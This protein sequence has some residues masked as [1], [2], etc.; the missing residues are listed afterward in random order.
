MCINSLC[1]RKKLPIFVKQS[2]VPAVL[3]I[4]CN[5]LTQMHLSVGPLCFK[6]INYMLQC[7]IAQ[8]L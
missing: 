2:T 5:C 3:L 8:V 7:Y 6:A 4:A 1:P